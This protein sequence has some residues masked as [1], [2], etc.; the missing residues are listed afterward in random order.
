[1][2]DDV[3][4]EVLNNYL[5]L[6]RCAKGVYEI[7][8]E[9]RVVSQI[10]SI[11]ENIKLAFNCGKVRNKTIDTIKLYIDNLNTDDVSIILPEGKL[12]LQILR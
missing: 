12:L 6:L 7:R 3:V 9:D 4:R 10:Q 11:A 5:V 1:M 8:E 2:R